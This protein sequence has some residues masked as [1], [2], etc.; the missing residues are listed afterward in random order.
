MRVASCRLHVDSVAEFLPSIDSLVA[1][2]LLDA[3]DLVEFGK[4]LASARSSRFDLPATKTDSNVSDSNVFGLSRT[5]RHHD[6]PSSTKS[7]LGGL[8][9]FGD[10]ADLVNLQQQSVA[11]L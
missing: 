5:M 9:C 2:F 4:P 10:R 7:V 11:G 1:Q 8:N 3:E 6:A